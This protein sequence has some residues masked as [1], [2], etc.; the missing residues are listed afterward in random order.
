MDTIAPLAPLEDIT[1]RQ[2]KRLYTTLWN[3]KDCAAGT[4]TTH[5]NLGCPQATAGRVERLGPFR[6]FYKSITARYL[7]EFAASGENALR[8]HDD[9]IEIVSYV[10]T[11]AGVQRGQLMIDYFTEQAERNGRLERP[12]W[13]D[14]ERAFNLAARILTMVS[15]SAENQ[16][17]AFLEEG[18]RP[19]TWANSDSL[20]TFIAKSFPTTDH[21]S[22]NDP[23]QAE[24][25]NKLKL[26]LEG[27]QLTK[28]AGLSFLA[29]DNLASHL[30]LDVDKG[31]V[32]IFH[33]TRALKEYLI[34]T[35]NDETAG[36]E[37]DLSEE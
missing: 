12:S 20:A 27:I 3:W 29:T 16:A 13:H 10:K 18:T 5:D 21:P 9:L 22:L 1:D 28:M 26:S 7:P 35:H 31:Y 17:G 34:A 23:Y 8:S 2:L 25:V 30:H 14:Q 6:E 36:S 11:R 33:H 32:E 15:C 24:K 19:I 37:D 4:S